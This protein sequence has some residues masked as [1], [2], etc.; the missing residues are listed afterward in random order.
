VVFPDSVKGAPA[1]LIVAFRQQ[2]QPQV[3]TWL[4]AASDS[5]SLQPPAKLQVYEV[6][7]IATAYK[8]I[9]GIIDKGMRSGIAK[10]QHDNVVTY[11]GPLQR[12]YKAFGVKDKNSCYSFLLD[13][14]GT[15]RFQAEGPTTEAKL[16]R[17]Q[18]AF[19]KLP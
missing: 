7:M 9:K 15:V 19:Q 2:T 12:Y 16:N 8:P 18:A 5:A 1:L 13:R 10:P 14:D 11:F 17:L 4:Q 6:P 3:D